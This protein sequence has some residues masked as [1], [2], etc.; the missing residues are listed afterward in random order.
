[1]EIFTLDEIPIPLDRQKEFYEGWS[2]LPP[3][4]SFIYSGDGET[5][6]D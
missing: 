6:E 1:M 4:D 2:D 5:K 3:E